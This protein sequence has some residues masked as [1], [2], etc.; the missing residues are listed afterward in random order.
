MQ[1]L[2]WNDWH[3]SALLAP[4]LPPALGRGNLGTDDNRPWWTTSSYLGIQRAQI[5]GLICDNSSVSRK[6]PDP[7]TIGLTPAY[8]SHPLRESLRQSE[9]TI[10]CSS[11]G[12]GVEH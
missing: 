5:D 1:C 3:A 2:D 9:R 4:C 11:R 8:L 7:L 10:Q 12:V 6:H